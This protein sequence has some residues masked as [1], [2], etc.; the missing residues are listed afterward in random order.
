MGPQA[1]SRW[2]FGPARDLA[3]VPEARP[4]SPGTPQ[5][6]QRAPA[7]RVAERPGPGRSVLDEFL[8]A[9]RRYFEL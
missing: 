4:P 1:A 9:S 3:C 6:L 2:P 7:L 5:A 8:N